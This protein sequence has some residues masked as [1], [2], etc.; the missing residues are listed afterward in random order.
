MAEEKMLLGGQ[1]NSLRK[2]TPQQKNI[3]KT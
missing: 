3:S 2:A 1:K